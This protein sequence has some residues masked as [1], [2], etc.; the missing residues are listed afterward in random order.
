LIDAQVE[1]PHLLRSGAESWARSRFLTEVTARVAEP[2]RVG[3]WADA[4]GTLSL[5]DFG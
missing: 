2:G 5:G 1:N 4:F 3:C